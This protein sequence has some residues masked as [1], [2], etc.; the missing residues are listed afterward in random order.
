[1]SGR[2][3]AKRTAAAEALSRV[4]S[5]MTLG[6]GTGS[7]VGHFLELLG[8]RIAG[9]ELEGVRGVP[10]SVQTAARA[11]SLGIALTNLEETP[12]PDLAVDG[13]DEV[14]PKFD[15][16]KG[17]GGAL[18]RE[19]IV[20]QAA[21]RFLVI[22]DEGKLVARLGERSP[23]PV[24]VVPFGWVLHREHL[25]QRGADATLRRGPEGSPYVTDN[26]NYVL[27]CRF[28]GPLDDP[29]ALDRELRKRA[30]VVAT[31]L[32]LDLADEVLVG[33]DEGARSVTSGEGATWA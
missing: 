19:K 33:S 5:G 31:G 11:R 20:A 6:L 16:I 24:E 1:M 2:E 23:L 17:M 32:F 28:P 18:L 29:E 3:D 15:L 30:G 10:T 7:T 9:G 22:V 27:D 8:D 21:R 25:A 13:A 14:D 26:G 12:A 4:R